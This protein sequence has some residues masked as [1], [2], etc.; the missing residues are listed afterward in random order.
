M[1]KYSFLIL[2]AGVFSGTTFASSNSVPKAFACTDCTF[3]ES[4]AIA[5]REAPA[6]YCNIW[7]NGGTATYCEPV[8][9]D[10]IVAVH[11]TKTFEK[12]TVTTSINSANQPVVTAFPALK[13]PEDKAAF[14]KYFDIVDT[15]AS[16]TADIDMSSF[17]GESS[18][19]NLNHDLISV[20]SSTAEEAGDCTQHPTHYFKNLGNERDVKMFAAKRM[21]VLAGEENKQVD[22]EYEK[23]EQEGVVFGFG[24][25]EIRV[26]QVYVK[27]KLA[28]RVNY[29]E[30]GTHNYL[31]F[32]IGAINELVWDQENK[33]ALIN[34][35]L[36]PTYSR[37]D[38]INVAKL[39]RDGTVDLTDVPMS[40]CFNEF[41][42]E[43][44]EPLEEDRDK[45]GTG[46]GTYQDPYLG[47]DRTNYQIGTFCKFKLTGLQT[48]SI[49]EDEDVSCTNTY[50]E[51]IGPCNTWP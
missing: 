9:Q 47:G 10:I 29:D 16:L 37:I 40:H 23:I 5:T 13:S 18:T 26:E 24:G 43:E 44:A 32:M 4:K 11:S 1:N 33:K 15:V 14:Q 50:V 39:F 30:E 34:L 42:K 3:E 17:S 46:S 48:C 31:T 22:L 21:S 41:L 35:K 45:P 19:L 49:T 27:Q 12:F 2:A 20:S 36:A 28:V 51:W 25:S 8:S 6:N 38:G 7:E